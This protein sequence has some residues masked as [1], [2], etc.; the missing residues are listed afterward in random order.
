MKRLILSLLITCFFVKVSAQT[1]NVDTSLKFRQIFVNCERKWV[2]LPKNDTAKTYAYGYIYID[3]YA[4]FTFDLQGMFSVDDKGRYVNK[5]SVFPDK[6]SYKYRLPANWFRVALLSP[7]HFEELKIEPEPDWVKV[8]YKY[9][10]T[11]QHNFRLGF[12]YNAVDQCALALPYLERVYKIDPHYKGLEFEMAFAYNGLNRFDEAIKVLEPA[13]KSDP[14]NLFLYKELGYAYAHKR[15]FEKAITAYKLGLQLTA[16][17]QSEEK[18]EMAANM[19]DAYKNLGNQEEY[20]NWMIKG[21]SYVPPSSPN[22]KRFVNAG[23]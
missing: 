10:D 3:D 2:V 16:E 1:A 17:G 13:V 19:A 11:V 5:S 21:K 23:F 12:V 18:G 22:Y 20:R 14:K 8:Y 6:A 7:K 4:G 9:T 15:L